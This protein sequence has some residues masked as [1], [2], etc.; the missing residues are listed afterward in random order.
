[1][2]RIL[3]LLFLGSAAFAVLTVAIGLIH[4]FRDLLIAGGSILGQPGLAHPPGFPRVLAFNGIWFL[5]AVYCFS[6]SSRSES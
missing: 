3:V 1:M 6:W 4:L 2:G 5:F